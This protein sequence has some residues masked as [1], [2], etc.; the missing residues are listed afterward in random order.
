MVSP[1]NPFIH[2]IAQL[3]RLVR[4]DKGIIGLDGLLKYIF[5]SIDN[6]FLFALFNNSAHAHR[7]VESTE[8]SSSGI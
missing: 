6:P 7:I 3:I 4:P 2:Q 5:L 1:E 8:A